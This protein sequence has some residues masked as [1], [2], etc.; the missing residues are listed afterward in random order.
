MGIYWGEEMDP[1]W[2]EPDEPESL[3]QQALMEPRVHSPVSEDELL[4]LFLQ[5]EKNI[6][7]ED[8]E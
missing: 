6:P 1:R 7:G 3:D 2:G 5:Y 4:D 8:R